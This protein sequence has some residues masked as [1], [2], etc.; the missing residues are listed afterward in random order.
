MGGRSLARS[1]G[2][3]LNVEC[4]HRVMDLGDLRNRGELLLRMSCC[5]AIVYLGTYLFVLTCLRGFAPLIIEK[6]GW[7]SRRKF[8]I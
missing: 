6:C 2:F 8:P 4:G 3:G 7:C 1:L 5:G